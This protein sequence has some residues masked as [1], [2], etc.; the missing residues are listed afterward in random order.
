MSEPGKSDKKPLNFKLLLR[1][2]K[3]ALPFKSTLIITIIATIILAFM[4][5]IRTLLVEKAIDEHIQINDLPGLNSIIFWLIILLL[6]HTVLQFVQAYLTGWLGQSI[7]LSIRKK[8]FRHI[9]SFKLKYFDN[10]PIGALVT[11][12]TSD[13][14]SVAEIFSEGIINIISDILQLTIALVFMFYINWQ[15]ALI[16]LIPIP[17]LLYSTVFF[18]NF[19]INF[20]F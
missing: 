2:L 14:Q 19:K 18:K 4:A 15:L 8:I 20:I 1:T 16:V 13:I 11:R 12:V 7:I 3:Y 17:I 5:P 6:F 9:M 10:H